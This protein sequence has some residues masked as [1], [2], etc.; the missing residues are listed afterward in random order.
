MRIEMHMLSV[1]LQFVK[2]QNWEAVAGNYFKVIKQWSD[3]GLMCSAG[4]LTRYQKCNSSCVVL[5]AGTMCARQHQVVSPGI[6]HE[7]LIVNQVASNTRN[8]VHKQD[9]FG[10]S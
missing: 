10:R 1:V 8:S 7:W 4:V 3:T 5:R 2:E 6:A 9:M